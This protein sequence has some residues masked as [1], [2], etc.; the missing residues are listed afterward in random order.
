MAFKDEETRNASY[1]RNEIGGQKLALI[2][3]PN[4]TIKSY[5]M[6]TAEDRFLNL[7]NWKMPLNFDIFILVGR[8]VKGM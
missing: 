6:R 7:W 8:I 1:G 5:P 4:C 3:H 2:W